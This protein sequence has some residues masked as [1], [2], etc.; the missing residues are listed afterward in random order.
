[1]AKKAASAAIGK[2]PLT[3]ELVAC[4]TRQGKSFAVAD[5][6]VTRLL[7]AGR[8]LGPD[9]LL[10]WLRDLTVL[11][12]TLQGPMSSPATAEH[13]RRGLFA[14]LAETLDG[15]VVQDG[16][17]QKRQASAKRVTADQ[18]KSLERPN[19]TAG[20]SRTS[21]PIGATLRPRGK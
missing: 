11:I 2:H 6:D 14:P 20:L 21:K 15:H 5:S 19:R 13:L 3:S 17:R 8:A 9:S 18:L 1:M 10:D 16:A 12:A 4:F 7:G